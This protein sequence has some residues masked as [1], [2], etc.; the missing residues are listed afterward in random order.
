MLIF[1]VVALLMVVVA[2]AFVV[3]PLLRDGVPAGP[4]SDA[5]SNVAIYKSQRRELDEELARGAMSEAEHGAAMGELSARVVDEVPEQEMVSAENVA[6]NKRPWWLVTLLVVAMPLSAV[7]LY[8]TLGAPRAIDMAGIAP[9]ANGMPVG[10]PDNAKPSEEPPMSDKQI[11][12]M[13]DS[14][15]KK[16][17]RTQP[18]RAAGS[19]WRDRRTRWGATPK[20]V[21]RLSARLHSRPTML[22]SWRITLTPPL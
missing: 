2:L 21:R 22:S 6:I 16:C 1:S 15:C 9:T 18:I 5:G 4:V 7:V 12:A 13:V 8:G 17:S 11:L 20:R 3:V 19:C 14:L 10:H